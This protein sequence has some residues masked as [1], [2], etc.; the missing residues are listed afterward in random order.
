MVR[1]FG[2]IWVITDLLGEQ[3]GGKEGEEEGHGEK[4]WG[5]DMVVHGEGGG[6]RHVA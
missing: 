1:C 5:L 4:A 3:E 6:Y 2:A